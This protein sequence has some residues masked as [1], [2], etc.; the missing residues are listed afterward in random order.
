[1]NNQDLYVYFDVDDTSN[2][3]EH[4]HGNQ[5]LCVY[6]GNFPPIGSRLIPKNWCIFYTTKKDETGC[7]L[8]GAKNSYYDVK[9]VNPKETNLY[10]KN[11]NQLLK[12]LN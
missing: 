5:I 2:C 11:Y 9:I 3:D 10:T 8:C 1:M 4:C 7:N 12:L 6:M